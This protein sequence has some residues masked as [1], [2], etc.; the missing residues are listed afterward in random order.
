M[1][2]QCTSTGDKQATL[3]NSKAKFLSSLCHEPEE[4]IK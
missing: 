2:R 4:E 3:Q 1:Q